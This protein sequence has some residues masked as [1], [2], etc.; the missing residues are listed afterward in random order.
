MFEILGEKSWLPEKLQTAEKTWFWTCIDMSEGKPKR[1]KFAARFKTVEEFD[2]FHTEFLQAYEVNTKIAKEKLQ[3]N[4]QCSETDQ[5]PNLS[6]C[7]SE[8]NEKC[9][10]EVDNQTCD[11]KVCS[12]NKS[13]EKECQKEKSLHTEEKTTDQKHQETPTTDCKKETDQKEGCCDHK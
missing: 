12:A 10:K 6:D 7:K 11:K 8:Q 9:N 5:K 3:G 2:K 1:E 13:G 4:K